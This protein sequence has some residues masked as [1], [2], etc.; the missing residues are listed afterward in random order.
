MILPQWLDHYSFAQLAQYRGLGVWGCSEASPF[1]NAACLSHAFR[2]VLA[3]STYDKI[4]EKANRFG[5]IVKSNPGQYVAAREIAKL[6][7]SGYAA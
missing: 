7:A 4:R 6:A 2:T 5:E 1:W 3:G